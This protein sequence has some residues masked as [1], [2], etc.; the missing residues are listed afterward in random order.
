MENG[1]TN[2][3]INNTFESPR[4]VGDPICSKVVADH[5]V[6]VAHS[7][8][9]EPGTC[10]VVINPGENDP[11]E[12]AKHVYE[13]G[14]KAYAI[15]NITFYNDETFCSFDPP[16]PPNNTGADVTTLV[17]PGITTTAKKHVFDADPY[18]LA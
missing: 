15:R 1:P 18:T 9:E 16:R 12:G 8:G 13:Y 14:A 2:I 4:F 17:D 11:T 10:I 7:V 3:P 5:G 6:D